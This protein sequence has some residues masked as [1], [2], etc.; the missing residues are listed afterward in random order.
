MKRYWPL[1]L[2]ILFSIAGGSALLGITYTHS[3]MNLMI[4]FSA[5]FFLFLSFFK[6]LDL[7]GFSEGFKKYDLL[8]EK[9]E[10]YSYF[11]PFLELLI[12]LGFFARVFIVGVAIFTAI[13]MLFGVLG[14][15][16]AVF[17]KKEL[18]CA[19]MGTKLN[20]PLTTVSIV[21]NI[22]MSIMSIFITINSF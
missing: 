13:L 6:L 5:F 20:L 22:G 8:A 9:S 10:F 3:L 1:I 19:C 21:E 15:I 11:Y 12:A 16:N 17:Q 4:N 2:V 7:K 18:R 14:V